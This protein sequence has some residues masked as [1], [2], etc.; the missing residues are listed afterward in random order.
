M[1]KVLVTAAGGS[2]ATGFIRSL[3]CAPED[4][5]VIGVDANKYT[6]QRSEAD[7]NYL[8]PKVKDPN[9]LRVLNKIIEIEK[10][11]LIHIQVSEEMLTVSQYREYIK[12][13]LF[14]PK[15]E[16]LEVCEDKYKSYNI[17]RESDIKVPQTLMLFNEMD[18]KRA[19]SEFGPK[20][21]VRAIS[22]SAGRGSLPTD[23]YE[24]AKLWIDFNRGWGHFSAAEC[25]EEQTITW[26]S[27]WKNGQLVVAQ[28]RKRL[29]W[30]FSNRSPS[31]VT[32]ITGTGVTVSDSQL[33]AL[34]IRAIK[35]I[36]PCPEGIYGV[37]LTFDKAG[38][39]NPTEINAGRFFTTH[40]FFTE[41]GLNMPYIFVKAALGQDV[42]IPQRINP[43]DPGLF[44]I[45][46][47]DVLPRLVKG[48][49]IERPVYE[50]NKFLA[51]IS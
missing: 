8:V 31:G 13:P 40:Q 4:F 15:H 23:N 29:Y 20:L 18:L 24:T 44:W 36:D 37:D 38:N 16:V 21:W 34:A 45:R 3:K 14:L 33:D 35:A 30:E 1:I 46:G 42:A 7:R 47:M 26:Q 48:D 27:I 39:P 17:W 2:P 49:D 22:G 6:L 28:G 9:Y 51:E 32:G 12:A 11:D 50:L 41:A 19:F 25:L 5:Y 10:P 43:L